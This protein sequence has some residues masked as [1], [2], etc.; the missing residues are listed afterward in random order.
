MERIG[1]IGMGNIGPPTVRSGVRDCYNF[2]GRKEPE[3]GC[4]LI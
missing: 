4:K 2:G 3:N 1:F